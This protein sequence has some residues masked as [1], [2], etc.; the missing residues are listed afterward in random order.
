MQSRAEIRNWQF[1]AGNRAGFYDSKF[2]LYLAIRMRNEEIV[3]YD[4]NHTFAYAC[5]NA[6][7]HAHAPTYAYVYAH[8][9]AY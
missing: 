7:A 8:A 2:L 5:P 3:Y 4:G 1:C 6:H 9:Y